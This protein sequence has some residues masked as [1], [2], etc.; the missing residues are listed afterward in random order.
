MRIE[1]LKDGRCA[2][3]D[4]NG[5]VVGTYP[6]HSAAADGI[7][8]IHTARQQS[9]E[10][11]SALERARIARQIVDDLQESYR[12]I[13]EVNRA[14]QGV[15]PRDTG[16]EELKAERKFITDTL[17]RGKERHAKAKAAPGYDPNV[18]PPNS[19]IRKATEA[20]YYAWFEDM[21]R[22]PLSEQQIALNKARVAAGEVT[23]EFLRERFRPTKEED[24]RRMLRGKK[25]R[26]VVAAKA[27]AVNQEKKTATK[28]KVKRASKAVALKSLKGLTD[29]QIAKKMGV[30]V[31]TVRRWRGGK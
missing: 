5:A 4:D 17:R 11:V 22:Q 18:L 12:K 3:V 15:A 7:V 29:E 21:A 1:R 9:P 10:Q 24:V 6:N 23:E 28:K 26:A 2:V 16:D 30:N 20:R 25:P 27:R 31:R 8:D 19:K 13:E 14:Q